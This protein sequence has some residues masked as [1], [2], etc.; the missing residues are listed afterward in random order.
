MMKKKMSC[1][2]CK[3]CTIHTDKL[4]AGGLA[5]LTYSCKKITQFN[6]LVGCSSDESTANLL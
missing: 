3:T 1:C 2:D 4:D 5:P 6:S